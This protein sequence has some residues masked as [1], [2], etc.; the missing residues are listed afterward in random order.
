MRVFKV[1][2]DTDRAG[3]ADKR[4]ARDFLHASIFLEVCSQFG[5]LTAEV[6]L[7]VV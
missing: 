2:D 7:V 1:A 5:D 4:T 6:C 3:K